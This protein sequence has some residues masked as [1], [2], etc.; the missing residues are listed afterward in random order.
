MFLLG[1]FGRKDGLPR[2]SGTLS[3]SIPS[4]AISKANMEVQA[5][6]TRIEEGRNKN[7]G[8][9]QIIANIEV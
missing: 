7:R 6:L 2:P 1:Y 4:R 8:S 9:K 3:V 5:E